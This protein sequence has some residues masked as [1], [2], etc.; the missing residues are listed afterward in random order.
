VIYGRYVVAN[1]PGA[2]IGII[3]QNDSYGRDHQRAA[4][5]PGSHKGQ[6]VSQQASRSPTPR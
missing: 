3:Y 2:K 1:P 5:G 6:I 4:G